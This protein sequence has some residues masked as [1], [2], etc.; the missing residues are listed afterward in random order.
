M[1][2]QDG[3]TACR[4]R[5]GR[6]KPD[7]SRNHPIRFLLNQTLVVDCGGLRPAMAWL[8]ELVRQQVF[9]LVESG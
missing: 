8:Q 2:L 3:N 5:C 7:K 1:P 4:Y 9:G 6:L